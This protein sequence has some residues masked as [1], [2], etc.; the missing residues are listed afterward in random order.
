LHRNNNKKVT[1]ETDSTDKTADS[2]TSNSRHQVA[3]RPRG[4]TLQH[5]S[6]NNT[7]KRAERDTPSDTF[8]I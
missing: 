3:R 5:A 8:Q 6:D 4:W 7:E 1:D 2:V